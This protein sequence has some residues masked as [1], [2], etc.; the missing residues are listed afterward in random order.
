MIK[1]LRRR[2][3]WLKNIIQ[4]SSTRRE[5][6]AELEQLMFRYADDPL[7]VLDSYKGRGFYRGLVA[8]QDAYEIRTLYERVQAINPRVIV[9]IGTRDGASL[10]LWS[11]A[12]PNLKTLVSIDLPGGIHGGGYI[13]QRS[14]LYHQ[15]IAHNP[16]VNLH[17][18]RLDSQ[19]PSTKAQLQTILNNQS[20]D[21]LFID[22][23]HRYEGVKRD[24]DL[25][26]SLVRQ[27]GMI[28]F[29]DIYPNKRDTSIQVD[30]LWDEIKAT[31]TKIEEIVHQPYRGWYG[32]GIVYV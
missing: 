15:F 21:F 29:H 4:D 26:R 5:S 23:D 24:Y 2:F 18:L 12:S 13:K 1:N 22:G 25:Y 30:R 32:I 8:N 14:Y 7:K 6:L 17:L 10:Y 28:A 11:Q 20:I 19:K 16:D 3:W 9:E 27:G 31:E